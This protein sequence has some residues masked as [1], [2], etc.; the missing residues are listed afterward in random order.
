MMWPEQTSTLLHTQL[1]GMCMQAP[2]QKEEA[3]ASTKLAKYPQV[4]NRQD[5]STCNNGTT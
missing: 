5:A 4:Q 2:T 3:M 1:L